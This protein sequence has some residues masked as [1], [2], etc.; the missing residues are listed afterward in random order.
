MVGLVVQIS[1]P[2]P[3]GVLSLSKLIFD[4]SEESFSLGG[5]LIRTLNIFYIK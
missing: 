2:F 5:I 1:K 4:G 3:F